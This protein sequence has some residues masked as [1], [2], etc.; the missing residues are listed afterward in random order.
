MNPIQFGGYEKLNAEQARLY[1]PGA[2]SARTVTAQVLAPGAS[3]PKTHPLQK[4]GAYWQASAPIAAGSLYRFQ[5]DGQDRFDWSETTQHQGERWNVVY[6]RPPVKG[7]G[8]ILDLFHLSFN[9][10][11]EKKPHYLSNG[12]NTH[13][14]HHINEESPGLTQLVQQLPANAFRSVLLRPINRGGYW[15]V[16]PFQL[17]AQTFENPKQLRTFLNAL[18][19]NRQNLILDTALVNQG[20]QGPQFLSNL[21]HGQRS[22]YW[23]WFLSEKPL[24]PMHPVPRVATEGMT[25]GILPTTDGIHPDPERFAIRFDNSPND[26]QYN[27]KRPSFII[28]YDPRPRPG[29]LTSSEDSIQPYRFPVPAHQL[30]E[31]LHQ[32]EQ[33][34]LRDTDRDYKQL[35]SHWP[36]FRLD[37]S[38]MDDSLEKWNGNID[39]VQLN[40]EN[41]DVRRYLQR[42]T[43]F[44]IR[45]ILYEQ[46][47]LL[48]KAQG[49][50]STDARHQVLL[51]QFP[52]LH[53]PH[54]LPTTT[55]EPAA[56]SL[57][58]RLLHDTPLE[59]LRIPST[60]MGTLT[61][62]QPQLQQGPFS[63]QL[64]QHLEK[65]I[66]QLPAS[67]QQ[68]LNSPLVRDW[69]AYQ[70]GPKLYYQLI[71]GQ[72]TDHNVSKNTY[73]SLPA[74]ILNTDPQTGAHLLT[75]LMTERLK[76]LPKTFFADT[77]N[78]ILSPLNPDALHTAA[79]V[80]ES[81]QLGPNIRVDA[82]KD[83]ANFD[84]VLNAPESERPE[85]LKTALS[86]VNHFWNEVLSP[87]KALYPPLTTLAEITDINKLADYHPDKDNTAYFDAYRQLMQTFDS[88]PDV[89]AIFSAPTLFTHFSPR[90]DQH[91][92]TQIGVADQPGVQGL[93]TRLRQRAEKVPLPAQLQYQNMVASHDYP[94]QAENLLKNP[95]LFTQD[96]LKYW[97]LSNDL[98]Q[99]QWELSNKVDFGPLRDQLKTQGVENPGDALYRL[100]TLGETLQPKM[101]ERLRRFY[102]EQAK[103]DSNMLMPTPVSLKK[104][105]VR[106]LFSQATPQDLNLPSA[107][108]K[109]A[110]QA[111][112]T[113]RITEPSETKAT[114]AVLTNATHRFFEQSW[115]QWAQ[116]HQQ[117]PQLGPA[118]QNALYQALT[119]TIEKWDRHFGYQ[120]LPLAI[121]RWFNQL[122]ANTLPA[123]FPVVPFKQALFET[124][125][126]SVPDKLIAATALQ[127]GVPGQPS[128]YGHDLFAT[129][130]GEFTNNRFIQNRA[131]ISLQ[132]PW[133]SP[134]QAKTQAQLLKLTQL[135]DQVPVLNNGLLLDPGPQTDDTIAPLIRDNGRDQ[136]I[137]LVN[138]GKPSPLNYFE[139]VG[140][141]PLYPE[142]TRTQPVKKGY[143]LNL[144][145][146]D[147]APGTV[148]KDVDSGETL[149]VSKQQTLGPLDIE[150][151]RL[152]VREN[153][154]NP[155]SV[156]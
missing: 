18:L 109:M 71:T 74:S 112:V 32:A 76:H 47:H 150:H 63:K 81:N 132:A 116:Q 31:K 142:V 64:N 155:T 144:K 100:K 72:S 75:D 105:F 146:L 27:P 123:G 39:V 20:L 56:P 113:Q 110:L 30:R 107:E 93:M 34:N 53:I 117:D 62:T 78:Q 15:T 114:R 90:P 4:Q 125:F 58:Q 121:D 139:K 35:F 108:A 140:Q 50:G 130:G 145:H 136:A 51:K 95:N 29:K 80:V 13:F 122:P 24:S 99:V 104:E 73:Q 19:K 57:A 52:K 23:S 11:L 131:P 59:A 55:P 14:D 148:Y 154:S 120:P 83:V 128:I 12:Q 45:R 28:L 96:F 84:A 103:K 79:A 7:I 126:A 2:H 42:A 67:Q 89:D 149:T 70:L 92:D 48:M 1:W 60:L 91:G 65:A 88:M 3:T 133:A 54:T 119:P 41:P 46:Y 85:R 25:L 16:N 94:T 82:A 138:S 33:Q 98:D 43:T 137:M 26:P 40:P 8:S 10:S 143:Q 135:R 22:P 61:L 151:Y 6:Q 134:L 5:I 129:T 106:W 141:D 102:T 124:A 97:G 147:V 9:N 101:P 44:S 49:Q 111:A 37:V 152:L 118:L 68:K 77:L 87:A 38:A 153:T 69:V 36:H 17:D 127:V 66:T 156:V 115:P 21:M 86:Q